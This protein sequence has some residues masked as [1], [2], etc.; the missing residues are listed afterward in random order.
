MGRENWEPQETSRVEVIPDAVVLT[1]AVSGPLPAPGLNQAVHEVAPG[2]RRGPQGFYPD[3]ELTAQIRAE[4]AGRP[5][6]GEGYR[7]IWAGLRAKG[8][9]TSPT[10]T[11]RLMRESA[12]LAPT[13][14]GHPHGPKAHELLL[15]LVGKSPQWPLPDGEASAQ[16]LSGLTVVADWIASGPFF[17]DPDEDWPSLVP[18]AVDAAGFVTFAVR[19][20]LSF[21]NI[22]SFEPRAMGE[23]K[24]TGAQRFV[25]TVLARCL[26]D[27]GFAARLRRADNPDTEDQSWGVLTG[28]GVD[29]NRETDS[30][31][32][33]YGGL[34]RSQSVRGQGAGI[35]SGLEGALFCSRQI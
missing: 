28:L 23:E 30:L 33:G 3:T 12:L 35:R 8:I 13:R 21:S 24:T 17:D 31:P 7:K 11:L 32:H 5:F 18:Q 27:R 19:P 22:F 10:R 6:H 2:R 4:L 29:I 26:N 20:Q 14:T 34:S 25:A 9:R 1:S 16:V 15:R